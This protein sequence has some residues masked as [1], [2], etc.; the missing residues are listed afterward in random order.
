MREFPQCKFTA[1]YGYADIYE[2]EARDQGFDKFLYWS[3]RNGITEGAYENVFFVTKSG[4][5]ITQGSGVLEGITRKIVLERAGESGIFSFVDKYSPLHF[6]VL[7]GCDE[8]FLTSTTLHVHPVLRIDDYSFKVGK[9]T[10]TEKTL[11]M[12]LDCREN[13]YKERGA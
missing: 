4:G 1:G 2:A 13:Y 5:L 12:F 11:K 3:P 8:A 9:G 6:A 10:Y 7:D